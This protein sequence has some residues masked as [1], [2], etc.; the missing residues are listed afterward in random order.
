MADSNTTHEEAVKKLGALIKDIKFAML[1]S[2]DGGL[3]RARPMVTQKTEF[4]GILWFLTSTKTHKVSEIDQDPRVCIAYSDIDD[5]NYVSVSGTAQVVQD[6][7]KIEEMWNPLYK[8]WFPDGLDD[9][10]IC[11]LKVTVEQAEYW[12]SPS[13]AVAN[14]AGFVKAVATGK[15]AKGGEHEQVDLS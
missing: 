3:L 10:T 12:D 14:I 2:I 7:A 1:T 6:R 13:S 5:N 4:D 9:P 8:A 11:L 15:P